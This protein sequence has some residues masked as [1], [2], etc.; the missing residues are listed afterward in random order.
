MIKHTTC[1]HC[2]RPVIEIEIWNGTPV[3]S[4]FIYGHEDE[5]EFTEIT[6]IDGKKARI[7]QHICAPIEKKGKRKK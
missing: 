2:K 4:N 7:L 3:R 6:D 5:E 1:P